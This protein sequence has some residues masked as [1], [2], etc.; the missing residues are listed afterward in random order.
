[1]TNQIR[2]NP[3]KAP[4]P[5]TQNFA[6]ILIQLYYYINRKTHLITLISGPT[7]RWTQP[8]AQT[9]RLPQASS[10]PFDCYISPRIS[11]LSRDIRQ[12]MPG[13]GPSAPRS[14]CGRVPLQLGVGP[15]PYDN[16][17]TFFWA[18]WV[19]VKGFNSV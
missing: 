18:W 9:P 12:T 11:V 17:G 10:K 2:R 19:A 1:M 13:K 5:I 8:C 14:S 3:K 16:P 15:L 7:A 4:T 6:G